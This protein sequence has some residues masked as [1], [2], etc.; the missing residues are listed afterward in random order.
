MSSP[1]SSGQEPQSSGQVVQVSS[2]EQVPFPHP[3]HAPQST[4]QRRQS[5]EAGSHV[6]SP[7]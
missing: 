7:Q 3:G 5:S 4:R 1:H 2:P 6:P